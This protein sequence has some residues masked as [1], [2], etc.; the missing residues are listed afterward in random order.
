VNVGLMGDGISR[1]L[2]NWGSKLCIRAH[3]SKQVKS[4]KWFLYCCFF[5][6]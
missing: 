1:A 2:Q 4:D 5:V 3:I 6:L